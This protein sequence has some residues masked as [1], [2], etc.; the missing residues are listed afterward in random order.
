[1]TTSD[2]ATAKAELL[3]LLQQTNQQLP[4]FMLQATRAEPI[5]CIGVFAIFGAFAIT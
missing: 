3:T 2:T 1:M 4:F 5:C